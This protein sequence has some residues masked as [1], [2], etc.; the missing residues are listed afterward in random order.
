MRK[1]CIG[2]RCHVAHVLLWLDFVSRLKMPF[3]FHFSRPGGIFGETKKLHTLTTW[4][5]SITV[6]NGLFFSCIAL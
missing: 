3:G 6:C 1:W 4:G 5:N 2:M